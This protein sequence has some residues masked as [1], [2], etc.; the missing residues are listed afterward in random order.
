[1]VAKKEIPGAVSVCEEATQDWKQFVELPDS[2]F[3]SNGHQ[4]LHD[5]I[6]KLE[7]QA[8]E[9]WGREIG[10]NLFVRV[11]FFLILAVLFFFL[12]LKMF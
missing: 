2:A 11:I 3:T 1:M 9:K 10:T 4:R 8:A 6:P 12:G 7:R 5:E